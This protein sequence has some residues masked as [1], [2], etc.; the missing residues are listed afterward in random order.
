MYYVVWVNNMHYRTQALSRL[1]D[2]K[3]TQTTIKSSDQSVNNTCSIWGGTWKQ[4]RELNWQSGTRIWLPGP[5]VMSITE[6]R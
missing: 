5:F 3:I 2:R 6:F 4:W 1:R